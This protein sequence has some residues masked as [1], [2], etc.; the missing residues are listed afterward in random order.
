MPHTAAAP[1]S[2][3]RPP[4][5]EYE[6]TSR[7]KVVPVILA[8]ALGRALGSDQAHVLGRRQSARDIDGSA[9]ALREAAV[10]V[11]VDTDSAV[12]FAVVI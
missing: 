1:L 12:D 10:V 7:S 6:R 11:D 5:K 3:T 8:I 9:A 2:R 4:L